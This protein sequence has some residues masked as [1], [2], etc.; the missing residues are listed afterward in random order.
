MFKGGSGF[1]LTHV[2]FH[3]GMQYMQGSNDAPARLRSVGAT[4]AC[5]FAD[6]RVC[7]CVRCMLYIYVAMSR[8]D[9]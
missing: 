2:L 1:N 3:P 4:R 8:A 7:V 5:V 6:C 9:I